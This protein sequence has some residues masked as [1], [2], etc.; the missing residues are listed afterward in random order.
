VRH[1]LPAYLSTMLVKAGAANEAPPLLDAFLAARRASEA[2][3]AAADAAA[4]ATAAATAAAIAAA[5]AAAA[6]AV[7][8]AWP[9]AGVVKREANAAAAAP[10]PET[11]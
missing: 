7:P 10:K 1:L 9:P 11:G 4:A 6:A 2:A 5:A 3:A 8:A